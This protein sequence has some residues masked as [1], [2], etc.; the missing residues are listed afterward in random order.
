[1]SESLSYLIVL[2]AGLLYG[3]SLGV[4]FSRVVSAISAKLARRMVRAV[5]VW[6]FGRERF[7]QAKEKPE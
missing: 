5:G 7:M 4:A 3:F 6:I 2:H 1:M